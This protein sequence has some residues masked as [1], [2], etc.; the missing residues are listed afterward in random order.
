MATDDNSKNNSTD[1]LPVNI[2]TERKH[3]LP[4]SGA[5]AHMIVIVGTI[6]QTKNSNSWT[7][8]FAMGATTFPIPMPIIM[9]LAELIGT[10]RES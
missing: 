8:L 3:G 2:E 10:H 7:V 5:L 4:A 6:K 9:V 1:N